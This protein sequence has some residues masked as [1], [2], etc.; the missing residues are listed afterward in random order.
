[1]LTAKEV[2]RALDA[3]EADSIGQG[4]EGVIVRR[5]YFYRHGMD[6]SK[7]EA[8]IMRRLTAAGLEP[9]LVRSGD[10]WAPF[11][12]GASIASSSHFYVIVQ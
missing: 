8:A 4:K 7:F 11:R 2:R 6:S 1:M 9:K 10:K 12:G 3:G 5:G